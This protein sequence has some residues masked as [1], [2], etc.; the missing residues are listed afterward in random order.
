MHNDNTS[1][2]AHPYET[3][4]PD[5]VI[6]AVE[7]IGYLSDARIFPLNSYENRVYQVGL[8]EAEPLIVKFYRPGRWS[9]EQINEEHRF[10]QSL[11]D[12]DIPSVPAINLDGQALFTYEGFRFS[13]Y[14]R[15]GGHA[16]ELDNLDSLLTLGRFIGRIHQAGKGKLFQFRHSLS[17]ENYGT[18]SCQFLLE[19]NF[20]PASLLSSYETL[21]QQLLDKVKQVFD[22]CSFET[23]R[24]HGDCHPGN[25]LWRDETPHFVDFDDCLNGPAIQDLW[26]LLS[27]DRQNQTLQLSEII[28]GYNEFCDFHPMELQLIESLRTLRL[29]HYS[30]WLARR[31]DDPAFPHNFPW[32]NTEKYWGEHILELREQFSALDEA[33]LTLS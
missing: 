17:V 14:K 15:Q 27:G 1:T 12:L 24:L 9:D 33:P 4:T 3:L 19:H 31:W 11:F 26:M 2:D 13:V 29:M 18:Q 20:L 7:S 16:P 5:T 10:V 8:E 22:H 21:C 30:A 32:F 6:D 25:V 23:I 28:E